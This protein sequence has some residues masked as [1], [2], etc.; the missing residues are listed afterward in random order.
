MEKLTSPQKGIYND[1]YLYPDKP[2]HNIGGYIKIDGNPVLGRFEKAIRH[3]IQ[4]QTALRTR[5]TEKDGIPYQ[6]ITQEEDFRLSQR[7]IPADDFSGYVKEIFRIPFEVFDTP[8]YY[9]ELCNLPEGGSMLIVKL[10]HFIADGW[11]MDVLARFISRYYDADMTEPAENE[12]RY[13]DLTS[14]EVQFMN[15]PLAT[16]ASKYY[17]T[18]QS[19]V[20]EA[21]RSA[22]ELGSDRE[23]RSR[24]Y[25]L[26]TD[27]STQTYAFCKSRN[28]SL[29]MIFTALFGL[30]LRYFNQNDNVYMVLP[31]YNRKNRKERDTMGMYTNIIPFAIMI[32]KDTPV[33]TYLAEVKRSILQG[34]K[35]SGYPY[36]EYL[37]C[38]PG[39]MAVNHYLYT[40]NYYNMKF[41]EG[42]CGFPASYHEVTADNQSYLLQLKIF[43]W[44]DGGRIDIGFDYLSS[45]Y[46]PDM[47]DSMFDVLRTMLAGCISDETKP[48]RL[49]DPLNRPA[50][51]YLS[52]RFH[53]LPGS[54]KKPQFLFDM[55]L[56][57][58]KEHPDNIA[59]RDGRDHYT[60]TRF[61]ELVQSFIALF[62]QYRVCAG[63][64]IIIHADHS[65]YELAVIFASVHNKVVF[66]P[67]DKSW[68]LQRKQ[69]VT[70]EV[71]PILVLSD[72][73]FEGVRQTGMVVDIHRVSTNGR[74]PVSRQRR[75]DKYGQY[76]IFTSGSSGAPKGVLVS[77]DSLSLYVEWAICTYSV[78]S[79]D[80]FA[81]YTSLSFD[82]TLTSVFVPL[83]SGGTIKVFT[84]SGIHPVLD[85]A[86]DPDITFLKATPS[87]LGI[88][89]AQKHPRSQLRIVV[90]GGEQL[91]TVLADQL[92][93]SFRQPV[94]I[95]NE[96]GPT[97]ATI[98]CMSYEYRGNETGVAVPV[99][100]PADHAGI[101]LLDAWGQKPGKYVT[102]EIH[103]AG[104]CLAEGYY[105]NETLTMQH[106]FPH[107]ED[108]GQRIYK[109]GDLA[110]LNADY[111]LVY[112]GRKDNQVK[113]RGYRVELDE[114][115][116]TLMRH[117]G[118]QDCEIILLDDS[119]QVVCAFIAARSD[120]FV[121]ADELRLYAADHLPRYMLPDEYYFTEEIPCT[122]NGKADKTKLYE[123]RNSLA[124]KHDETPDHKA[125]G[126]A[127]MNHTEALL[128]RAVSQTLGTRSIDMDKTFSHQ[129]GDSIHAILLAQHL[130]R[131]QY[132]I[133]VKDILSHLTLNELAAKLHIENRIDSIGPPY[134]GTV[135][136]LPVI[137][138]FID[139]Q[140]ILHNTSNHIICIE[141]KEDISRDT[142]GITFEKIIRAHPAL[143]LNISPDKQSLFYC[144]AHQDRP[145]VIEEYP[146]NGLFAFNLYTDL[147]LRVYHRNG[148]YFIVIN[149][150]VIDYVSWQILLQDLQYVLSQ[151]NAVLPP[152]IYS[153]GDFTK[154][155]SSQEQGRLFNRKRQQGRRR[156]KTFYM[157]EKF[158]RIQ[159]RARQK[160]LS[161]HEFLYTVFAEQL[162]RYFHLPSIE[163]EIEN[164]GRDN[165]SERYMNLIGWFTGFQYIRFDGQRYDISMD[166]AQDLP[167]VRFNYLGNALQ[168]YDTFHVSPVSDLIEHFEYN[169]DLD[170]FMQVD[171]I[172]TNNNDMAFCVSVHSGIHPEMPD[173]FIQLFFDA[174]SE[175]LLSH[176]Q[177][178]EPTYIDEGIFMEDIALL[179]ES[180]DE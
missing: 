100:L 99:G 171:C 38:T 35:H 137:R 121:T 17:S 4:A 129:G 167:V 52:D 178:S 152:E 174:V 5:I 51:I 173:A 120:T 40:I 67:V 69:A 162:L 147:L 127:I 12:Y 115:R 21:H 82:L 87:H 104:P 72:C 97:E 66:I 63:D 105:K 96:Y 61:L 37:R 65:V 62:E 43:D 128:H 113:I 135:E 92:I 131:A 30:L 148:R 75:N 146:E 133:E 7:T 16:A 91:L 172:A 176:E 1:I 60:Y 22:P 144:F 160:N 108:D 161:E 6:Y 168:S 88:I 101:I 164:T 79:H 8:L 170:Y 122:Q 41:N 154:K 34:Y 48:L 77:H 83:C 143:L 23:A 46:S 142:M 134:Y 15:S 140:N 175:N 55:F 136:L 20:S 29:N 169:D 70:D 130:K 110:R 158:G 123:I 180:E 106:F 50:S 42:F 119:R 126:S 24:H 10:H 117:R 125:P 102:G 45:V 89:C 109:T 179:L 64:K 59:V 11:S 53:W 132:N 149:H 145:F 107:P 95:F 73:G 74:A 58:V 151:A 150:L 86:E 84:S 98:G 118:V 103:I 156:K 78:T 141:L 27:E 33:Y 138:R 28:I 39:N 159:R 81:L 9:F 85:I 94:R 166:S 36:S 114:I 3:L 47:I 19:I 44:N 80:V 49:I 71:Q 124:D 163:I 116:T 157:P 155:Y 153:Y 165:I 177:K 25:R 54:M 93:G 32:N 112:A 26:S 18:I 139:T 76:I 111:Q 57:Q 31:V 13:Q 2:L 68:P 56:E 14:R 90:A